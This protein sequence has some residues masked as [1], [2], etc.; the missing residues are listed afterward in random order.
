MLKV[1]SNAECEQGSGT[2]PS[3]VKDKWTMGESHVSYQGRIFDDMI[4]AYKKGTDSCQGDS[5]GPLT[6][7]DEG[8]RHPLIGVV[9]FGAGCARV[10]YGTSRITEYICLSQHFPK[11]VGMCM[12]APV[13]DHPQENLP[14]VY[15]SVPAQRGWI[16]Q[17]IK[18]N[19][20]GNFCAAG[21]KDM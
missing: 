10:S 11:S 14:G 20:G 21:G 8:G 4:C 13:Q 9:S 6:V 7:E 19:G 15:S 12:N 1:I 3:C 2:R 17:E 18:R 16:D 5:G